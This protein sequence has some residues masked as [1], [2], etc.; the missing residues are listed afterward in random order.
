MAHPLAPAGALSTS[1][2]SARMASGY[3]WGQQ[4][5]DTQSSPPASTADEIPVYLP[6]GEEAGPTLPSQRGVG[7]IRNEAG[8]FRIAP[9]IGIDMLY[10]TGLAPLTLRPDGTFPSQGAAGVSARF[11][12]AGTRAYRQSV[13]TLS[14]NGNYTHYPR[15]EA[16]SLSNHN[17]TIGVNH[18]FSRRLQLNSV[19]GFGYMNNSFFGAQGFV[20]Y[21]PPGSAAPVDEF[22]NTPVFFGTTTQILTYQK[23]AR[24]SFAAGG[25]GNIQRR[26]SNALVG[27]TGL[28]ALG[29]TS[30]RISRRQTIGISYNFN[31]FN[32]T[33]Q[34]GGSNVHNVMVEYGAQPTRTV[35]VSLAVGAAR[36]ESQALVSVQVD[37]LIAALFGTTSGIEAS[38]RRNY[39]P[40]FQGEIGYSKRRWSASVSGGRMINAGNGIVLTNSNSFVN[41]ALRYSARRW[42]AGLNGGYSEM[43]GLKLDNAN[44][45]SVAATAGFSV[46]LARGFSWSN[47]VSLRRFGGEGSG[48]SSAFQNREQ[49][50]ATS[51]F[52]WSPSEF[53]LPL[54]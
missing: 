5:G 4:T 12:V 39:L 52:Y 25:G 47:S 46:N 21:T 53:P 2:A 35:N 45:S 31:Q 26:R 28:N 40:T 9:F 36:V 27:V 38:Y 8:L 18:A 19:N 13:L 42:S 51:G 1:A 10:D 43:V 17:G 50:Q 44:F 7:A 14:Y 22:F 49:F 11:G 23:S 54:F 6:G 41:A 34:Y 20:G 32:F 3:A 33:N 16:L 15:F 37:P 48:F 24:L 29:S 30:F